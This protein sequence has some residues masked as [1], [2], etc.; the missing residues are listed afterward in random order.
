MGYRAEMGSPQ[1]RQRPRRI[2]HDSKGMLSRHAI[3]VW[4]RGH[5]DGGWDTDSPRGKRQMTT[6]ANDPND[7]PNANNAT[8]K[9]VSSVDLQSVAFPSQKHSAK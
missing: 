7:R 8:R 5:A 1:P 4:H 6:F 2:N 3:G 9:R